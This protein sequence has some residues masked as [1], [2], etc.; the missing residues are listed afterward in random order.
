MNPDSRAWIQTYTGRQVFPF[1]PRPEDIDI[2]DIAHALS[3]QCRFT[4]HTRE[5]Y[6]VAQHS[7]LVSH[8]CDTALEGLLHDASEAYLADMAK[9]IK[10]F[11]P[12]YK[13]IEDRLMRAIAA[14]FS[15][16]YPLSASVKEAD[17]R[18]LKT[19]Q[20]DLLCAPLV[21]CPWSE[22]ILPYESPIKPWGPER[23]KS[24]FMW[25]FESYAN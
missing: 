25:V 5:F 24:E 13:E 20:R 14:K 21:P 6:S 1:A 12:E 11:L 2:E 17:A 15:F 23:A 16:R 9:P 7:C 19:E 3:N 10:E 8:H 4:G 18:A 22:G